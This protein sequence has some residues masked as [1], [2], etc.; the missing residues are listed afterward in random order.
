MKV[1]LIPRG[2]AG[3][4]PAAWATDKQLT[5]PGLARVLKQFVPMEFRPAENESERSD[6]GSTVDDLHVVSPDLRAPVGVRA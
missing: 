5:R 3:G 6:V 2:H 1:R 4:Q